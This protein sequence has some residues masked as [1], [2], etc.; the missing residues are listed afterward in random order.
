MLWKHKTDVGH[1]KNR[2]EI[3]KR[4]AS[5]TSKHASNQKKE[6]RVAKFVAGQRLITNSFDVEHVEKTMEDQG[7]T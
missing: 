2:S 1:K 3:A 4:N 7:S 5:K 6:R